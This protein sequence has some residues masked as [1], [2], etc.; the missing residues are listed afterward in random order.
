ML[1]IFLKLPGQ[2]Y[3]E[4]SDPFI[5]GNRNNLAATMG[6]VFLTISLQPIKDAFID[7]L[8]V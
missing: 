3:L 6:I 5:V 2:G 7:R 4:N 1:K 8:R